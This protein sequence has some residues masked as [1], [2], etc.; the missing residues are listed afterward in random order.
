MTQ[1]VAAGDRTYAVVVAD[2]L[3]TVDGSVADH[4]DDERN[5]L[6]LVATPTARL[7]V[8][9]CGLARLNGFSTERWLARLLCDALL[10]GG[11]TPDLEFMRE[12]ATSCDSHRF[13]RL[14]PVARVAGHG[15]DP[16]HQARA[17]ERP[18]PALAAQ[19]VPRGSWLPVPGHPQRSTA[20]ATSGG[21]R[22]GRDPAADSLRPG[23]P[24]ARH[25]SRPPIGAL[26][27]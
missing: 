13:L 5:K 21:P 1:I 26:Q 10:A 8:A 24:R 27:R 15:R 9:Y 11:G 4:A 18:P 3:F 19:H 6:I 25:P 2:R 14:P 20:R 23:R 7:A 22:S 12:R 17:R 16:G